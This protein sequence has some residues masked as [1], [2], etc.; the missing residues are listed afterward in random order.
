MECKCKNLVVTC[1]YEC[2][3]LASA[4]DHIVG[5]TDPGWGPPTNPSVAIRLAKEC[6]CDYTDLSKEQPQYSTDADRVVV[7]E[8][9]PGSPCSECM[10]K[11]LLCDSHDTE[12]IALLIEALDINTAICNSTYLW[13]RPCY[14]SL[15][16]CR[17]SDPQR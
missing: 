5:A 16:K 15:S 11:K 13:G 4:L 3:D 10:L 12:A 6:G 17:V 14:C 8:I 1:T 9:P 7:V 2:E